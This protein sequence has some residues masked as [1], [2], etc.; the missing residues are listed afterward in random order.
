MRI[1]KGIAKPQCL[2]QVQKEMY[3]HGQ[4][5]DGA[6]TD[7]G[8]FDTMKSSISPYNVIYVMERESES[9]F[10]FA[11]DTSWRIVYTNEEEY[12][13]MTYSEMISL[14]VSSFEQ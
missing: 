3:L 1:C 10:T 7:R 5:G 4:E 13:N 12:I 2:L 11:N 8:F 14:Y 6:F 9:G